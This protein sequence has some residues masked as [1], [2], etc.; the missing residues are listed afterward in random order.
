MKIPVD[1]ITESAKE[2]YVSERIGELNELYR[3]RQFRDFNFPP[4]L[5]VHLVYYRSGREIFFKGSL[6]G[7]LEGRCSRCLRGYAFP[8]N[9][10]FDFVLSPDPSKT[11][12][13]VEELKRE[14]LGLSY[15]SSAEINLAPLIQEQVLLALPTRPLC[16]ENC[17]G[18][19]GNC[20]AN[21]NDEPCACINS[22]V[23]PRMAIFRTL[24]VGR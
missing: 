19:C 10:E 3:Q 9:K 23:D 11:G 16:K 15:Y 13:K 24:K 20:G 5:D 17:R 8:L 6:D 7:N 1:E 21:L 14:D 12:R 18:L 4:F 22:T 2:I